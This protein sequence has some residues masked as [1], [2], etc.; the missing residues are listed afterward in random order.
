MV[1][2]LKDVTGSR[3]ENIVE[4]C[5]TDY[6][7]FSKSLFNPAFLGD[8]WPAIEFF[9]ELNDVPGKRLYFFAQVKTT[10]SALHTLHLEI[11]SKRKDI[12]RLLEI[13]GPTYILGVHEPSSRVFAISVHTGVAVKAI[14]KIPLAYELTNPNLQTSPNL[15]KLHDEVRTYWSTTNH[16][17][18]TSVF[19]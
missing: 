14:T 13:P 4:L 2:Q 19:T 12:E 3:G 17:P 10:T 7:A 11:S 8:K 5:L 1:S 15:Q 18:T 9:V 6:Q 16:K